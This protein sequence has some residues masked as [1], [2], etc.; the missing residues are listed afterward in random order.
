S[1][2]NIQLTQTSGTGYQL[3]V[4]N[5]GSA[6]NV[7]G[8]NLSVNSYQLVE[9][10]HDGNTTGTL[11]RNGAQAAQN[12][13]MTSIPNVSR[14]GNFIGKAFGA[15]NYFQG[16][17]AEVLLFDRALSDR[18]RKSIESY[19]YYKYN[20]G[21]A[22]SVVP[23]SISITSGT[24]TIP[25]PAAVVY[26]SSVTV[27]LKSDGLATIKY[28]TNGADPVASGTTYTSP[29]SVGTTS[30]I[31]AVAID[32]ASQSSITT[33][34]I[35][36]DP[37]VSDVARNNLVLWLKADL[38]VEKSGSSVT[39]IVDISG[40]GLDATSSGA[41]SPTWI[42]SDSNAN[43]MPVIEFNGSSNWLQLPQNFSSFPAGA[44]MVVIANPT[45]AGSSARF[46]DFGNGGTV[47][48]IMLYMQ[49][50]TTLRYRVYNPG[51]T[52]LDSTISTGSYQLFEVLQN[53]T[54]ASIFK[55]GAL[56]NTSS[57]MNTIG[58]V[59][60]TGNYVGQA[61]N[62]GSFFVG[63]IAEIL[64]YNRP[65]TDIER[66]G[67]E[68]YAY[69]KYNIASQP[70]LPA[71][72][73]TPSS[74]YSAGPQDITMSGLSGAQIRY[75]LDGSTPTGAST[76]YAGSFT[77]NQTTTI[78]AIAIKSNWTNS[79]VTM[80]N[81]VIDPNSGGVVNPNLIAWL[82]SD[83]FSSTANG[84][85]IDSWQDV[86]GANNN[87]T[88]ITA[89][90]RPTVLKPA[91]NGLPAVSFNGSSN[92]LQFPDG[93]SDFSQ[94][95]SLFVVVKPTT[96]TAGK[97]FL[98]IGNSTS[99]NNVLFYQQSGTDFQL[100]VLN[101]TSPTTLNG[102]GMNSNFQLLEAIHN[103]TNT[104]TLYRNGAQVAQSSMN[105]INNVTRNANFLGKSQTG[106]YFAGQI[107]EVIFYNK[108]VDSTQRLLVEGYL[109]SKYALAPPVDPIISPTAGV[110]PSTQL[111]SIS[112]V[113]GATILYS[114]N[115]TDP[116]TQ[117]YTQPFT[118][119]SSATVRAKATTGGGSSSV[120]SKYI[121]IDNNVRNLPLTDPSSLVLWLKAD[122]A[123]SITKN[124]S[125]DVSAWND[126]SGSNNHAT[127]STGASQPNYVSSAVNG[128]P[129]ITFNGTSDWLQ[130]PSGMA[131]FT[132][133]M[134]IFLVVNPTRGSPSDDRFL[135]FGVCVRSS[136]TKS[137]KCDATFVAT[138]YEIQ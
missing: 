83:N 62:G 97:R 65:L 73:I 130:L 112:S 87:A 58:S 64:V 6:T 138:R 19:F 76:L 94:G 36:I 90:S 88:Q 17:I 2:N 40:T 24:T 136:D 89:G 135:D 124:G 66:N 29:F 67:I 109:N 81:I 108:A 4:L 37:D 41:N 22:P 119:S 129:A 68:A 59:N 86:S 111:I 35:Q 80:A 16:Q 49:N 30:T 127:Q 99:K 34:V 102:S 25:A 91:V 52:T 100:A 103:G 69:G 7:S 11:F 114:T 60:R 54:T 122:N 121:Q 18:E 77:V 12:T 123:N 128:L 116:P 63:R 51:Q 56:G 8:T 134:S 72:V 57:S 137:T 33:S 79:S 45:G 113:P 38:G 110:L 46:F 118:L 13:S 23:P 117:T 14:S 131:D 9:A 27:S 106:D 1:S 75:T 98:D 55:N 48:N 78:K 93:F 74:S 44:T 120:V 84:A 20:V 26:D 107:A 82:R 15:T 96:S 53:G 85:A 70:T 31:K 50:S 101:G 115:G 95:M 28:T 71:P 126:V 21:S 61:S 47:D 104:A 125:N 133:G 10:I 43:G 39:K 92:W 42:S 32:G 132:N 3:S 5:G 105:A